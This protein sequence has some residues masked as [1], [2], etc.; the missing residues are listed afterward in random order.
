MLALAEHRSADAI[1]TARTWNRGWDEYL[2]TTCGLYELGLAFE[3]AGQPDSALAMYRQ[4]VDAP[5]F[6]S[7]LAA[8]YAFAPAWRRLGELYEERGQ[9]TEA[10]EAYGR[11]AA[12]WK[13]ADPGL[14]P[15]V[16]EV[17]QRM[18]ALVGEH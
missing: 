2:C 11:F 15:A 12:L 14:Q 5:G 9:R 17:R 7:L 18:A 16:R 1:T 4:L 8:S 13:D 3:Q 6:G 10:I